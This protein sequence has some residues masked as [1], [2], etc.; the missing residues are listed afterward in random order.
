MGF[1]G[2]GWSILRIGKKI[3][4]EGD[5]VTIGEDHSIGGFIAAGVSEGSR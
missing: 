1:R 2:G 5:E 4:I 3:W